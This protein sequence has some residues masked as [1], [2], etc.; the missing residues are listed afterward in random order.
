MTYSLDP[1]TT[2]SEHFLFAVEL[3]EDGIIGESP[4]PA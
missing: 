4:A 3:V 2:S 1:T